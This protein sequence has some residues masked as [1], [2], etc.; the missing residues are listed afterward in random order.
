MVVRFRRGLWVIPAM[1]FALVGLTRLVIPP[2]PHRAPFVGYFAHAKAYLLST[3]TGRYPSDFRAAL[4]AL[5]QCFGNDARLETAGDGVYYL[6]FEWYKTLKVAYVA[7]NDGKLEVF[8]VK[9]MSGEPWSDRL[10][11]CIWGT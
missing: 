5:R 2:P 9:W 8:D 6:H 7:G 1:L 4:P 11:R 3:H 10:I